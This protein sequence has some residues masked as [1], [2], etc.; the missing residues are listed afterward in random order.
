MRAAISSPGSGD[1]A[2]FSEGSVVFG[3]TVKR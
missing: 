2:G 1:V 3:D